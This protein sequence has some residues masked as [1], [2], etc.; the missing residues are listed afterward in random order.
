MSF[1]G[2]KE[3]LSG[4]RVTATGADLSI[5]DGADVRGP[6]LSLLLAVSGRR[7]ALADLDGPGVPEL[8]G[9]PT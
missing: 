5:G 8:S 9:S 1:G 6:A 7:T 4:L 2:A 3:R